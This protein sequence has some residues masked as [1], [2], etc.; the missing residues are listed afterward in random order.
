MKDLTNSHTDR[1]NVLNNNIAI[2]EIYGQL[3]FMGILFENKY[4]YSLSQV[5]KFYEVDIRTI[6]R[7]LEENGEELQSSGYEL[8]M[9]LKLKK[10]KDALNQQ[11]DMDVPLLIQ[12]D[13][14]ELVG[15]NANRVSVFTFKAMLNVGMLLQASE[16]AKVVRTFILNVVIDVLNKKLG[17]STKYIN[18][19]EEEFV[20]AAIREINYRME[21]TNSIDTS[22]LPNKFK[23]AQLTDKIYNSIF[24]ENAKEYRKVLDLKAKESAR[25]TMYSEI[26]DLISSY[27]NGFA[28][29]LKNQ[30]NKKGSP[31]TLSES[32]EIFR[33]FE[34]ET[35]KIYEPL[36]EKARGLMAS[37]DMEFRDALHEKLKNYVNAVSSEDF[38]KFIGEKS[39]SLQNRLQEN[40]DVFKRLKDR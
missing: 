38:D 6:K 34:N 9:G 30:F 40:M 23:Y 21:F 2:R 32:H 8:F 33:S 5:A 39:Q 11:R 17:G 26:L 28:D 10:F 20:P 13:D 16:K 29:Y 7:L 19:R 22:I 4:R 18:Q 25:A 24:K 1:K 27:E 36:R 15:V 14:N 3:G 12:D 37:R 35:N 31:F